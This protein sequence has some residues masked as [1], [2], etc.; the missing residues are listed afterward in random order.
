MSASE[1][2]ATRDG[3]LDLNRSS[4]EELQIA[5]IYTRHQ[6]Q[7]CL[8]NGYVSDDD[9]SDADEDD[10]KLFTEQHHHDNGQPKY[11]RTWQVLPA[12]GHLPSVERLVEEKH[13]DVGGVC[14]V[15]THF[16]L[17]QP[18]LS[19]KHFYENQRMKSEKLF[20]VEDERTM[21]SRKA[22]WW[23]EYYDSGNVMSEMQYDQNGI[24][25]GFCKRYGPDGTIQWVK[26]YTKDY[27]ERL[28][29]FNSKKGR[30]DLSVEEACK[31]L[32]C[33]GPDGPPMP[34]T[35]Q[36]LD[37]IYRRRCAPLHPD[38]SK[39]PDAH[40][41]FVEVSRAREVIMKHLEEQG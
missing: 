37:R 13:F 8:R 38:K 18:Y 23:R 30:I 36:E 16:G 9:C 10:G 40:E 24:R 32:G 29:E 33:L 1:Q 26:D 2:L 22:G 17:G 39:D 15:D 3:C 12:K 35:K 19:R 7:V 4:V 27:L 41:R 6:T 11:K 34:Q 25:I 21:A 14:R 5:R 20:F 31:L 28:A